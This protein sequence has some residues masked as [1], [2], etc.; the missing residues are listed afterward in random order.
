MRDIYVLKY[1]YFWH[2]QERLRAGSL[3]FL[4]S[5]GQGTRT[6]V[7]TCTAGN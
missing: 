3:N 4:F 2:L 5:L 7:G 1:L 6:A